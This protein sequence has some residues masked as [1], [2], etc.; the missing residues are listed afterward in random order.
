MIYVIL[1]MH[2]SGTT[3]VSQILHN[4]GINMG[5]FDDQKTYD[6]GNQYERLDTLNFNNDLLESHGTPSLNIPVNKSFNISLTQEREALELIKN[7]SEQ[8]TDWG[9]KD[10][11]TCITYKFWRK[12]LPVHKI[13]IIYRN[14]NELLKHYKTQFSKSRFRSLKVWHD[15]NKSILEE[16]I[17]IDFDKR[18]IIKFDE[19]LQN[20]E[21]LEEIE[22]FIGNDVVDMRKKN[23][24]R[25]KSESNEIGFIDQIICKLF[26]RID[27]RNVYKK[28]NGFSK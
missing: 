3:L 22:N 27:L 24:Y 18:L 25:N 12:F 11:R 17:S 23:L 15:Y 1:G 13:I 28:L 7:I 9:F 8:N 2:K 20:E 5:D 26:Y 21:K 16:I 6:Q 10:P 4:S 19:L 14:P